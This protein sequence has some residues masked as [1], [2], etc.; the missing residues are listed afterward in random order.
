MN[1]L[2]SLEVHVPISPTPFF[3][4]MLQCLVLSLR[5]Y[6]GAYND[7]PVVVTIGDSTIV[8]DLDQEYVWLETQGV[9]IRWI[10]TELFARESWFATG[11]ERYNYDSDADVML[12]LDADI[13]ICK[14]LD[15]LVSTA[16]QTQ[17]FSAMIAHFS[18]FGADHPQENELWDKLFSSVGLNTP[19]KKVNYSAYPGNRNDYLAP[20]CFNF[21]VQCA[22]TKIMNKIG[23]VFYDVLKAVDPILLDAVPDRNIF[24]CQIALAIVLEKL[25]I[26]VNH[27]SPRYNFPTDREFERLY[28]E[29]FNA[30]CIL[31]TL[32]SNI[33]KTE[34]YQSLDSIHD[35]SKRTDLKG[36]DEVQRNIL[37]SIS[38]ALK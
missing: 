27:L 13:L 25:G 26:N 3:F 12:I 15:D 34:T 11:I 36:A 5:K 16:F 2:P 23:S 17:S 21:G 33:N 8:T 37:Q 20:N 22:S 4:N 31:H 7:A 38:K 35:V 32:G 10:D 29:E 30:L 19:E 6:G 18:P 9:E 24:R 1:N 14:P 28:P